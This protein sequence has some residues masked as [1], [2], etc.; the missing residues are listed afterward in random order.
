MKQSDRE[1][2]CE[3]EARGNLIEKTEI[4]APFGL[5]M[6]NRINKLLFCY[7][8]KYNPEAISYFMCL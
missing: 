4:A 6:T 1:G 2:R 7:C 8:E 5:T 3:G